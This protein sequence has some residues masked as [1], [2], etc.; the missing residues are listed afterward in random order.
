MKHQNMLQLHIEAYKVIQLGQIHKDRNQKFANRSYLS[1]YYLY[2]F[3]L[4][5]S[6]MIQLSSI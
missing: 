3:Q 6:R 5:I 1:N 4:L 2:G